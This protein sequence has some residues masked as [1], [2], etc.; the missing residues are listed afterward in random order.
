[1]KGLSVV[2][3]QADENAR[4]GRARERCSA[5]HDAPGAGARFVWVA[6]LEPVHAPCR[7]SIAPGVLPPLSQWILL[8][9]S[10]KPAQYD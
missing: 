5:A 3:F 2:C 10:D 1:M 7:R 4:D 8:V 6:Q 9:H